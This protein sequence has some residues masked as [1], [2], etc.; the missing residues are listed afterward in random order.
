MVGTIFELLHVSKQHL[1]VQSDCLARLQSTACAHRRYFPPKTVAHQV[2]MGVSNQMGV[3]G[4]GPTKS[5]NKTIRSELRKKQTL[6]L[7]L[8]S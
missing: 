7:I 1:V 4:C 2:Y 6:I 5:F 3:I 8:H